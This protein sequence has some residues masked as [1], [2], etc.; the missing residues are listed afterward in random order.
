MNIALYLFLGLIALQALLVASNFQF[1][2]H[3]RPG[4]F[5]ILSIFLNRRVN[6]NLHV[7]FGY[8]VF[9]VI[10]WGLTKNN[11]ATEFQVLLT[12]YEQPKEKE[13]QDAP[14]T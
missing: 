3:L 1:V 7:Y 14:A 5:E 12:F 2:F 9:D 13:I 4:G 10:K 6:D 8:V 11:G